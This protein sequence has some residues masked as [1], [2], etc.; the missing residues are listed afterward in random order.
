MISVHVDEVFVA[1]K[2]ETLKDIK[3]EIKENFN[4]SESGKVQNLLG[5]YYK[6]GNNAKG[7]YVEMT[8]EKDIK[9]LVEVYQNYTGSY[10]RVQKTSAA[11]GT[12]LSKSYLEETDNID[13]Y[14]CGI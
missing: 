1:G 14:S 13:K 11:P 6:W 10:L 4:I 7:T 9:K 8:M 12:T 5:V 2:P 3:E